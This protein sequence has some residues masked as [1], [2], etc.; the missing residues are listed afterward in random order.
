ML[1]YDD[2]RHFYGEPDYHVTVNWLYLEDWLE[3]YRQSVGLDLDPDFQRGHVWTP[4]QQ[5]AYVEFILRGGMSGRTL[6]WN[7]VNFHLSS[8]IKTL[9]IVDGKQRL[10]AVT[11]FLQNKLRVFG[12]KYCEMHRS[13]FRLGGTDFV[14]AVNNLAT[15]EDVLHWYLDLNSGGTPHSEEEIQR[16]Q[17]LL[18]AERMK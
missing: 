3:D 17:A 9:Q 2:I 16:V 7:S 14:M 11:E 18:H 1:H 5:V 6:Y 13:C 15:R 4:A 8:Q 12:H 10:K